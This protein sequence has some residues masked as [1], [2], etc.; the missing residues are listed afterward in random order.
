MSQQRSAFLFEED[1]LPVVFPK[2]PAAASQQPMFRT[3]T[4]RSQSMRDRNGSIKKDG[5]TSSTNTNDLITNSIQTIDTTFGDRS[6]LTPNRNTG[7][8][9][10]TGV[11]MLMSGGSTARMNSSIM[12]NS[13]MRFSELSLM[14][15]GFENMSM[16]QNSDSSLNHFASMEDSKRFEI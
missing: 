8:G 2:K 13:T 16:N 11:S 3:A 9:S 14:S 5:I 1:E 15:T 6:T 7:L 10:G 4:G 12:R